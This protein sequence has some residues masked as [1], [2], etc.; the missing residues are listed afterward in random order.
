MRFHASRIIADLRRGLAILAT[1]APMV[2]M[3]SFILAYMASFTL[4][5]VQIFTSEQQGNTYRIGALDVDARHYMEV[6]S[7]P[8]YQLQDD[9]RSAALLTM[10]ENHPG[11]YLWLD[12]QEIWH[13]ESHSPEPAPSTQG[14][15]VIGLT[16]PSDPSVHS[17]PGQPTV[18]SDEE[19]GSWRAYIDATMEPIST[20][21]LLE[22]APRGDSPVDRGAQ[23]TGNWA[24][25]HPSDAT[26]LPL[27]RPQ[28]FEWPAERFAC[29]CASSDLDHLIDELNS[30]GTA[31]YYAVETQ[32]GPGI[33]ERSSAIVSLA[34][35]LVALMGTISTLLGFL[36]IQSA[37]WHRFR[38]C[39]AIEASFGAHRLGFVVRQSVLI[40][41]AA[42]APAAFAFFVAWN[43]LAG[44]P[45]TADFDPGVVV[46]LAVGLV[47]VHVVLT[48]IS[49]AS[50]YRKGLAPNE[51]LTS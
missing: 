21:R 50:I 19:R 47:V 20:T 45:S 7:P 17:T 6:Q 41:A 12:A 40:L 14:I 30:H 31:Q 4:P 11:S 16:W 8:P 5:A 18:W 27:E 1:T 24:L 46:Y 38:R 35:F 22:S 32:S 37:L 10:T 43:M 39:Y 48:A 23:A 9:P 2:L 33:A 49:A 3:T 13:A 42:T 51:H 26:R 34:T 25:I 36:L 28:T 29:A 15:V 44:G